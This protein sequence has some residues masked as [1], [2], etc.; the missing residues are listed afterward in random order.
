[1]NRKD[2]ANK[3]FN[4]GYN[5]A[6]S[7]ILAFHKDLELD[8]ETASALSSPLGG[9]MGGLRRTCGAVAGSFTAIGLLNKSI[10]D[11]GKKEAN[12]SEAQELEKYF[13]EKF[14]SSICSEILNCDI[15]TEEGKKYFEDN[16]LKKNICEKCILECVNLIENKL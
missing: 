9:G 5:C 8:F 16:K 4:S 12:Y 14:G 6:Q 15:S 7:V 2:Q 10:P 1:M 11:E 13:S 3:Y